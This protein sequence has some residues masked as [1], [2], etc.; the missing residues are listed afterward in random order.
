MVERQAKYKNWWC[1]WSLQGLTNHASGI[2]REDLAFLGPHQGY[3]SYCEHRTGW[4]PGNCSDRKS[5]F[6]FTAQIRCCW[7]PGST[8]V[9]WICLNGEQ[10]KLIACIIMY[11]WLSMLYLLINL[12]CESTE[13]TSPPTSLWFTWMALQTGSEFHFHDDSKLYDTCYM[14]FAHPSG[15]NKEYT[16][17]P[18]RLCL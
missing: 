2:L 9:M 13:S 15:H 16:N 7:E 11:S 14:H 1:V 3:C 10:L 5:V 12:W 4:I 8:E 18:L 6:R 17:N